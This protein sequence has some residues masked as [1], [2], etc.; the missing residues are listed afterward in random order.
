MLV[1][2]VVLH[3]L[4]SSIAKHN[5]MLFCLMKNLLTSAQLVIN[6]ACTYTKTHHA[7][8]HTKLY[9]SVMRYLRKEESHYQSREKLT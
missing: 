5:D 6:C 2:Y 1:N 4:I 9:L 8:T 7:Y 3:Y